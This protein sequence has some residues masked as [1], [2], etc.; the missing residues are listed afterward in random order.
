M[1]DSSRS[2]DN[3]MLN[4]LF[5]AFTNPDRRNIISY[6]AERDEPVPLDELPAKSLMLH[7]VHLPKL[8]EANLVQYDEETCTPT[9]SAE[10]NE[11]IRFVEKLSDPKQR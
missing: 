5:D 11:L 4:Q 9:F 1:A 3:E 7:H 2:R 10:E 6:L 8:A